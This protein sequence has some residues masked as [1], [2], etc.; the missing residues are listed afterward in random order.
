[1][2]FYLGAKRAAVVTY[3]LMFLA[4]ALVLAGMTGEIVLGVLIM[5]VPVLI[6]FYI[7]LNV[8]SRIKDQHSEIL[9]DYPNV[10]SKLALLINAGM[11]LRAAW[12]NVSESGNRKLYREMQVVSTKL[13]NM[14]PATVAYSE[15][16][17]ACRVNEIK[18]FVSIVCQN[19]EK[20]GPDLTNVMKELSVD[21]WTIKKNIAKVK[22]NEAS[23]KLIIPVGI[24]FV[25]ILVMI[26]API[27]TGMQM[28][29]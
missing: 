23:T 17:D 12:D 24:S 27:M 21:A 11:T 6:P 19:L 18:K 16:A 9:F 4:I 13:A 2:P 22:G 10:L 26:L 14:V 8:D 15:L 28:G 7:N 5:I 29:F 25:A 1:M 3:A 20:G